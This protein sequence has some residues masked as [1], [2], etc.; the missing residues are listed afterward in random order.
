MTFQLMLETL[1]PGHVPSYLAYLKSHED[2]QH[3]GRWF[4]E[5]GR[6]NQ[7]YTLFDHDVVTSP[8]FPSEI[9]G[10]ATAHPGNVFARETRL[11][12]AAKEYSPSS[13]R[14]LEWREYSVFPG[15]ADKFVQ[16]MLG[17]MPV[18]QRYSVNV[19]VWTPLH[20]DMDRVIHLWA[21]R[22]LAHRSEARAGVAREPGWKPY[23]DAIVPLLREMQST[24]LLPA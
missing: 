10:Y 3:R 5:F 12:A 6:L 20:G 14:L 1:K 18:R 22:D 24:L 19:C 17:A 13:E 7:V 16:L 8:R 15:Q 23:T 21:Y 2:P 11:L 4:C 9:S